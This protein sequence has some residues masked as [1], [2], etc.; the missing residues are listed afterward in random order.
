MSS[1]K[2]RM[3][4]QQ[5]ELSH[6]PITTTKKEDDDEDKLPST[7]Q[8]KK[9][10]EKNKQVDK[11]SSSNVGNE[12]DVVVQDGDTVPI[13]SF[14]PPKKPQ[15]S[16]VQKAR[17][18][19]AERNKLI[20]ST[21]TAT[22]SQN[23]RVDEDDD[24]DDDDE[25][26][27]TILAAYKQEQQQQ[28][29]KNDVTDNYTSSSSNV[30]VLIEAHYY[31]ADAEMR[32]QLSGG[33][34]TG[35]SNNNAAVTTS[36]KS[37]TGFVKPDPQWPPIDPEQLR[38][39]AANNNNNKNEDN[40]ETF[41]L[42]PSSEYTKLMPAYEYAVATVNTHALHD[43]L[44][45]NPFHVHSLLQMY[46]MA[47]LTGNVNEARSYLHMALLALWHIPRFSGFS[48]VKR[49][50]VM[51]KAKTEK[52]KTHS[53]F[54]SGGILRYADTQNVIVF[55]VLYEYVHALI[56]QGCTRT[57]LEYAKLLWSLDPEHDPKYALL[58]IEYCALKCG[59]YK[60]LLD[61]ASAV[62]QLSGGGW[63]IG[64]VPTMMYSLALSQYHVERKASTHHEVSTNMLSRA[65]TTYPMVFEAMY[66]GGGGMPPSD[67]DEYP[68]FTKFAEVY[69]ARFG[70]EFWT[71]KPDVSQ[72]AN[73]CC[74]FAKTAL[75]TE[76]K[77][78]DEM[79]T[80]RGAVLSLQLLDPYETVTVDEVMGTRQLIPLEVLREAQMGGGGGHHDAVEVP[81]PP[82]VWH[83]MQEVYGPPP[84]ELLSN[85]AEQLQYY[86]SL[87]DASARDL[88]EATNPLVLFL[89]SILPWNSV[90]RM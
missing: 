6:N 28:T 45:R 58:F 35:S 42:T 74:I 63:D 90:E 66:S 20:S 31:D 40:E 12:N 51:M 64:L 39:N 53:S 62:K 79:N 33:R 59:E 68:I 21:T 70:N 7:M 61:F 25:D 19:Q 37:I 15:L 77:T 81:F 83:Q 22:N 1:R 41:V 55:Q 47:T 48:W 75:Q 23:S 3:L 32:R 8:P 16:K 52:K 87:L 50:L 29:K 89:R 69:V 13:Q 18:K 38:L 46:T 71:P 67:F 44:R 56:K 11:G 82:D 85:P 57:A 34:T 88:G 14:L 54:I 80:Q 43:V 36:S 30:F 9:K 60:F 73:H 65:I 10:K 84:E 5:L 78:R 17:K 26:I 2:M 27:E 72:W 86:Q 24:E 76:P 49:K 4:E